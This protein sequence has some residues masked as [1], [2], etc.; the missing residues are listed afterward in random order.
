MGR[1]VSGRVWTR[2]VFDMGRLGLRAMFALVGVVAV[3]RHHAKI[4]LGV[5]K[6]PFGGDAISR[7]R[8]VPC[9]RKVFFHD[10]ACI[11]TDRRA[12]VPASL[13]PRVPANTA[14]AAPLRSLRIG[15]LSH[16]IRVQ[17]RAFP[18]STVQTAES[19]HGRLP[20]HADAVTG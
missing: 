14:I 5:L 11:A 10:L 15:T 7:G 16:S 1:L 4:V 12:I 20:E 9:Q 2:P 17:T 3:R 19:D 8:C 13:V 18:R 6:I